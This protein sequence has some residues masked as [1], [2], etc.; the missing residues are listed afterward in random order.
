[1]DEITTSIIT[2]TTTQMI[3]VDR[4]MLEDYHISLAQMMENAGRSLAQL[5]R[6][7]FLN[8]D[9]SEK[10]VVILVGSGGNGGGALVCARR[11][12]NWRVRVTVALSKPAADY[13][14]VPAQQLDIL[15]RMGVRILAM[16]YDN[17][18]DD[19]DLIVDGIIGYSLSGT[20]RGTAAKLIEWANAQRVPILSLDVPSG[21]D[22]TTGEA[23]IPTIHA[24]ATLTLALPK[25]GL[26]QPK[27]KEFVG[28][29]YLADISVPPELY[30]KAFGFSVPALF[31]KS[32][33]IRVTR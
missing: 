11:L 32:D 28:E 27:T 21:L 16:E 2:L 6:E 33:I 4:A 17:L 9:P 23:H 25:T 20:P 18:P 13:S 12:H 26:I 1:M 3:E 14:G 10:S 5:A 15:Q 29:L 7:R 22:S 24:A 19:T 31:A 8:G 30:L